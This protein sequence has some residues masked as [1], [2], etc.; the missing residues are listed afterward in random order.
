MEP[1]PTLPIP[2]TIPPTPHAVFGATPLM[3]Q[4]ITK[5][6]PVPFI[7]FVF[8]L[9]VLIYNHYNLLALVLTLMIDIYWYE[10]FKFK[11]NYSAC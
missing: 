9:V 3:G 2:H 1:Q 4:D 8:I 10:I 6:L 11:K 7:Y 5:R